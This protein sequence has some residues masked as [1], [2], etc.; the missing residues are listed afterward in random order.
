MD[1]IPWCFHS[2]V[3]SCSNYR[4][5]FCSVHGCISIL[6]AVHSPAT[7]ARETAARSDKS[8]IWIRAD[9]RLRHRSSQ[10]QRQIFWFASRAARLN[11]FNPP[12]L[13]SA[14]LPEHS[15]H[16]AS[17][18]RYYQHEAINSRT[19]C[20]SFISF[21]PWHYIKHFSEGR[22]LLNECQSVDSS[23]VNN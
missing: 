21:P 8:V 17:Y 23:F 3:I 4:S 12:E 11:E 20:V 1:W 18:Y 7:N 22:A 15:V 2:S 10:L 6:S 14:E 13:E 16:N 5:Y 19:G 9:G